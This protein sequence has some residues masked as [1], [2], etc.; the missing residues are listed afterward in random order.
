MRLVK[1]L[2][3]TAIPPTHYGYWIEPNGTI[4]VVDEFEGHEAIAANILGYR[5]PDLE[6]DTTNYDWGMHALNSGWTRI[7]IEPEEEIN[8][9]LGNDKLTRQQAAV[10]REIINKHKNIVNHYFFNFI[11]FP[12][13]RMGDLQRYINKSITEDKTGALT[14]W[15]NAK[16][17]DVIQKRGYTYHFKI[18]KNHWKEMGLDEIMARTARDEYAGNA[19]MDAYTKGWIRWFYDA[20]PSDRLTLSF[21]PNQLRGAYRAIARLVKELRPRM[22]SIDLVDMNKH[23][24]KNAADFEGTD[25][26]GIR[27]WLQNP[28]TEASVADFYQPEKM[29]TSELEMYGAWIHPKHGDVIRAEPNHTMAAIEEIGIDPTPYYGE[30]DDIPAESHEIIG[31]AMKHGWVRITAGFG[32]RYAVEGLTADR[33]WAGVMFLRKHFPNLGEVQVFIDEPQWYSEIL[34]GKRLEMFLRNKAIPSKMVTE[35]KAVKV[36]LKRIDRPNDMVR[37]FVNPTIE[38]LLQIS[39]N[40]KG[41]QM[42][43]LSDQEG[44]TYWWDA[45]YEIHWN[46]ADALRDQYGITDMKHGWVLSDR[47]GRFNIKNQRELSV[48]SFLKDAAPLIKQLAEHPKVDSLL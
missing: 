42:R 43:G 48:Y 34:K 4:H 17:G 23:Y 16:S 14:G 2:E 19:Q 11:S 41:L 12:H 9:E 1:L 5:E 20:A 7:S 31:E 18:L 33:V 32:V 28:V 46:M 24:A 3:V 36:E 27:Q 29:S 10:V 13:Y 21:I 35:T 6:Y 37:V 39:R 44:N 47:G 8:F 45:Y 40:Q 25:L 30:Y 15:I 22:V 38:N 26:R